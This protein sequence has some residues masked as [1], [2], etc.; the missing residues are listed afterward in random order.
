[1]H[2]IIEGWPVSIRFVVVTVW[3][4]YLLTILSHPTNLYQGIRTCQWLVLSS[5]FWF[6]GLWPALLCQEHIYN[7]KFIGAALQNN[8]KAIFIITILVLRK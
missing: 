4:I 6:V 1:M 8:P 7:R 2:A 5:S 3:Y